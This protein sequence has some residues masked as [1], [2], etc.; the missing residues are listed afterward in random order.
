MLKLKKTITHLEEEIFRN[1]EAS[2]IKTK[3]DNFLF[4]LRSYRENVLTDNDIA[5][6]LQLSSNSFYVLKSRLYDRVQ[7]I[8]SGDLRSSKE[9]ILKMLHRIPEMCFSVSREVSTAYLEKLEKDLLHYDM[10]HELLVVYSALKKI[11][12]YSDK[13]FHYSQLYNRHMAFSVSLEKSEEILGNFTRALG[14]YK[15]SR[16]PRQLEALQF[17]HKGINDHYALN[18][19]RQI[20][21]IRNMIEIQL[22]IFCGVQPEQDSSEEKLRHTEKL[23]NEL[24]ESSAYKNWRPALDYLYFEYYKR[25]GEMRQTGAYFE[26]T[27]SVLRNLLLFTNICL[28]SCYLVSRIVYLQNNGK[29]QLLAEEDEKNLLADEKD[30]HGEV[31]VGIYKA[32]IRYYRG[33][34]KEAAAVLNQVINYNSFKDYFHINTD[35]KLTLAYFYILM[36]E[37]ELADN[38]LKNIQRKIK[39]EKLDNYA[40]VLDIIKVFSGDIKSGGARPDAR[41]K[42]NFILFSGRNKGETTLLRHL[43]YELHKR[44]S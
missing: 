37:F 5:E 39:A 12:L 26:K 44:Y 6:K 1:M 35:I 19:S 28:S 24:P 21:I 8:L 40:N 2:L 22:D 25:I 14:Q 23:L 9:E 20:E 30:T 4:L 38:I 34:L 33:N 7:E 11:H 42:D 13:Y 15:F 36:K 3:A 10:H 32:M 18:R 41:Q 43:I 27:E 29:A 31:L 16:S 17:L